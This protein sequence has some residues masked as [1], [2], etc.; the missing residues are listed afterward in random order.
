MKMIL[1][2]FTPGLLQEAIKTN[3]QVHE[4]GL[5]TKADS[6]PFLL[7]GLLPSTLGEDESHNV[8]YCGVAPISHAQ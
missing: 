1:L 7:T 3:P 2:Q 8:A 6:K 5:H 4:I